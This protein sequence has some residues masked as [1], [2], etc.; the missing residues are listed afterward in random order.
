M[1]SFI[2]QNSISSNA[3][4]LLDKLWYYLRYH[5]ILENEDKCF[6]LIIPAVYLRRSDGT[7]YCKNNSPF[8]TL[9]NT[10]KVINIPQWS[11]N[12]YFQPVQDVCQNKVNLKLAKITIFPLIVVKYLTF[13]NILTHALLTM[14][15][16]NPIRNLFTFVLNLLT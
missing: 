12:L 15:V 13:M 16:W 10:Q 14:K 9:G 11:E 4:E 5:N 1:I 2:V 6:K 3:A 8:M 7:V